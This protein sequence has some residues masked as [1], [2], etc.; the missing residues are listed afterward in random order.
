MLGFQLVR[1]FDAPYFSRDMGE[2]W[3][4]WH[5][6]FSFW[7]RDYL[8][9][10]LG[11]NR[12]GE[13]RVAFNLFLTLLLAG[14]WHG[15]DATFLLF[16]AFHGL[17]V[18]LSHWYR[19]L[20][21]VRDSSARWPGGVLVFLLF[22]AVVVFFRGQT[23]EHCFSLYAV[24]ISGGTWALTPNV[25]VSIGV[26]ALSA[27][28]LFG[29]DALYRRAGTECFVWDWPAPARV[30]AY[31]LVLNALILLGRAEEIQFVYFQF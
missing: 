2:F 15:S 10:P 27:A 28:A 1:N 20:R 6:S 3:R 26:A 29:F 17:L 4:R 13:A 5:I 8:Y 16:G 19:K 30:L 21:P 31:A 9:I 18:V 25:L 22:S 7:L 23:I 11:G 14:L 24:M 12:R